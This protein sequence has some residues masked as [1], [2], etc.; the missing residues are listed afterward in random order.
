MFQGCGRPQLGRRRRSINPKFQ[1]NDEIGLFDDV[2]GGKVGDYQLETGSDN[3][4]F[5]DSPPA[6][7]GSPIVERTKRGAA[8]PNGNN[9]ELQFESLNFDTQKDALID[10]NSNKARRKN[11]RNRQPSAPVPKRHDDEND[12][13][14]DP[15]LDKLVKD[16][17]QKVRDSRKF[18]SNLPYQIC[19]NEEFSAPT[20]ADANCWNGKGADR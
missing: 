2:N 18:W 1:I 5:D 13:N 6:E 20:S 16:I 11:N 17:K 14:K 9:R 10:N 8:L 12:E 19:N 15:L 4:S 3:F 7:A